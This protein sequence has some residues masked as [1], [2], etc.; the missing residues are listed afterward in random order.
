MNK[1]ARLCEQKTREHKGDKFA[2]K[3]AALR[4]M[5]EAIKKGEL[6][7]AEVSIRDLYEAI[8]ECR[9]EEADDLVVSLYEGALNTQLFKIAVGSVT[10]FTLMQGYEEIPRVARSMVTVVSG[11]K[12]RTGFKAR[13]KTP[14]NRV[15]KIASLETYPR[16]V[17]DDEKIRY[18]CDKYGC[19]MDIAM[20]VIRE[21]DTGQVLSMGEQLGRMLAETEELIILEGMIQA[22]GTTSVYKPDGIATSI[23]TSTAGT[24]RVNIKGS[25]A[26][27]NWTNIDEARKIAQAIRISADAKARKAGVRIKDLLVPSSLESVALRILNATEVERNENSTAGTANVITRGRTPIRNMPQLF[28]SEHLSDLTPFDGAAA[29]NWYAGDFKRA[30][31]L[32]Q[33][34]SAQVSTRTDGDYAFNNDCP[35]SFKVYSEFGLCCDDPRFIIL[36]KVS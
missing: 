24:Y 21:D 9:A 19:A 29:T 22:S 28:V 26:L 7:P 32:M 33:I 23:F 17:T 16:V 5:H 1:F 14:D 25:N 10:Q 8:Y 36:N 20:E 12:K 3:R 13:I 34:A 11:V 6:H 31:T 2:G 18:D 15:P 4:A 30:F 35:L 27:A